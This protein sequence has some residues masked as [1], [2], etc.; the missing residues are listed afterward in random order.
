MKLKQYIIKIVKIIWII[1]GI[2]Y[3]D[4]HMKYP[5]L[6]ENQ[7]KKNSDNSQKQKEEN[8]KKKAVKSDDENDTKTS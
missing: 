7:L 3:L 4:L 1:I 6:C 2:I 8:H 5:L